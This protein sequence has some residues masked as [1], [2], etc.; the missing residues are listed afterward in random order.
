MDTYLIRYGIMGH[1]GRFLC[2]PAS[3]AGYS[4]GETV[5]IESH[6]GLELGEVLFVGRGEGAVHASD[7]TEATAAAEGQD[8]ERAARGEQ[9]RVLRPAGVL[10]LEQ[11]RQVE[12]S[13]ASRFAE[14]RRVL[15]AGDW[16]WE[17]IDVEPLLDGRSTVIHYLGPHRLDATPWRR[18]FVSSATST[19][20]SNQSGRTSRNPSRRIP[21]PADVETAAAAPAA[22]AANGARRQSLTSTERRRPTAAALPHIQV[23]RRAGSVKWWPPGLKERSGY[24]GARPNQAQFDHRDDGPG[25]ATGAKRRRYSAVGSGRR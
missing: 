2:D 20:C 10:D 24:L 6:R 1:V 7:G 14:C 5:V 15:D 19:W 22:A 21:A 11:S 16:P 13:R 4:R 3:T 25:V 9:A 18:A 23:V 8:P 12:A 17:L